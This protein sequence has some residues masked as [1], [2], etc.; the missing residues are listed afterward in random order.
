MNVLSIGGSD[1]SSGAG[2]QS[3]V[4]TF[5]SLGVH[6]FT[7][8]TAITSQNTVKFS[9]TEPVSSSMIKDQLDVIFSDFVVDAIKIGMVYN[10]SIIKAIYSELKS[11]KVPIILDP[12]ILSTTNG[13]LIEKNALNTYKKLLIPLSFVITPNVSEAEKLTG[14]KISTKNDALKCALKIKGLGAKNVVI[15][16]NQFEKGHVDDFVLENT[17]RYSISGKKLQMVNH[18]SGC[19]YS[20]SLTVAIATG[21]SL[22]KAIKFAKNYAYN[23]IKNSKNIGKG[24]PITNF[25]KSEIE[26]S[27]SDSILDFKNL[28]NIYSLIPECQTNFVY[29]KPHPKSIHDI[30]GISGRIVRAGTGVNVAGNL[31][32]GASRHV[33]SAILAVTKKFPL[34]RSALNLR[35]DFKIIKK[36]KEEGLTVL[37]YDRTNEPANI[38]RKEN[39]SVLWGIKNS[40]KKTINPPDIIFHKGDFGKEP[41]IV[42]F[43]EN[44]SKVIKK[45]SRIL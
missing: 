14:F 34:I 45:I 5:T 36:F 11:V 15:T 27:L 43:G 25:K 3:D 7:V 41:M 10:S 35:Y 22:R 4:R 28:K 31:E 18:G 44:P 33:A 32:Y 2:I 23:S 17:M 1:P 6:G 9:K 8:V 38:K 21:K 20:A 19:N 40:I 12:V 30:L 13:S 26:K 39:T 24:V 29:S 16:G 37:S 42:V